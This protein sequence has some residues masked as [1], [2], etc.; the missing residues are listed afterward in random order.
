MVNILMG[1][2][3]KVLQQN[4]FKTEGWFYFLWTWFDYYVYCCDVTAEKGDVAAQRDYYY[5]VRNTR[6]E[7]AERSRRSG[8]Q[9]RSEHLTALRMQSASSVIM[10][11]QCC[12]DHKANRALPFSSRLRVTFIPCYRDLVHG[13][14]QTT[15][16]LFL[17]P[18]SSHTKVRKSVPP[19]IT[20]KIILSTGGKNKVFYPF[21][22]TLII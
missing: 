2:S 19:L 9:M 10:S 13:N 3:L 14:R 15:L 16:Q 1:R 6:A 4:L 12:H 20:Q 22:D 21:T 17:P 5:D 18:S 11:S 8:I 7:R